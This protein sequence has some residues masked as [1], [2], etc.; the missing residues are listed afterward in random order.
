MKNSHKHFQHQYLLP[1]LHK[2]NQ[3]G[4]FMAAAAVVIVG[5]IVGDI[6]MLEPGSPQW[7]K[8]SY[9]YKKKSYGL[10]NFINEDVQ[11]QI[12]EKI[13]IVL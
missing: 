8:S 11:L 3:H 6:A 9:I 2:E 5:V 13:T 1:E 4:N 10:S 12:T 7:C